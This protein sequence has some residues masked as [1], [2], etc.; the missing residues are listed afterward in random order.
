MTEALASMA[1]MDT[2]GANFQK[3]TVEVTPGGN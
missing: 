1:D 2:T 3:G